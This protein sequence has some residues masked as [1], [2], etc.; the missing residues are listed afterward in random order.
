V[1]AGQNCTISTTFKPTVASGIR[2]ANLTLNFGGGLPS[3]TVALQGT[4]G[5]SMFQGPASVDFG[6]AIVGIPFATTPGCCALGAAT[7]TNTGNANLHIDAVGISGGTDFHFSESIFTIDIA[8]GA[9]AVIPMAFLATGAGKRT[10]TLVIGDNAAGSPHL[11]PLTGVG[12]A[13]GDFGVGS[14]TGTEHGS[15][16]AT[17]TAGQTA[18]YQLTIAAASGFSGTITLNC[19]GLPTGAA[20]S[21]N[22]VTLTGPALTNSNL[23]ISTMAHS[24]TFLN[25]QPFPWIGLWCSLPLFGLPMLRYS[26]PRLARSLIG[27]PALLLLAALVSCGG[28]GGGGGGASGPPAGTYPIVVTGTG[29]GTSHS[30]NL[31]L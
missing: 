11:I 3:Q 23:S 15:N 19:S 7:I 8:P 2:T 10:A 1:A 13:S 25:P 31:T 16:S 14:E 22:P 26:K 21:S 5:F 18:T 20:C 12:V 4:A 29:G 9:S 17:V 6:S 28:G 24:T 27:W 30:T